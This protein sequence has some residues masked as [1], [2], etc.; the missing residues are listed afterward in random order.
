MVC[1]AR[2]R[3][4]FL[5]AIEEYQALL[6]MKCQ[7]VVNPHNLAPHLRA[8]HSREVREAGRPATLLAKECDRLEVA[9]F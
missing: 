7:L 8:A 1:L 9:K 6:C 4:D 3:M 5:R 2:A